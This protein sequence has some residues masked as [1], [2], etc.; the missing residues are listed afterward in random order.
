MSRIEASSRD[1][2]A[3]K[4]K[5]SQSLA[6][7]PDGAHS[8]DCGHST[9]YRDGAT[10]RC[11]MHQSTLRHVV[12]LDGAVLYR[13]VVPH[14]QIAG[15]PLVAINEGGLDD[16]IR[17]S[18][19]QCLGLPRL[20]A[21]DADAVV[22]HNIKAFPARKGVCSSKG[23][24]NGWIAVDLGLGEREGAFAGTEVEDRVSTLDPVPDRRRQCIPSRSG[25]GKL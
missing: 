8:S 4:L 18:R 2:R 14:E 21:L 5:F 16:V 6:D 23:M 11:A 25:T 24:S 10:H 3:L 13:A 17:K 22:T 1:A 20:H 15:T 19:N 12:I 7:R 9:L